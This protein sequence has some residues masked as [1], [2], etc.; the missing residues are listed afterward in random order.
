MTFESLSAPRSAAATSLSPPARTLQRKC[1]CGGTPGP[2]GECAECKRKRL[3]LQPKLAVNQPGD[4]YEQE[5]D[6]V[7]EAIVRGAGSTRPSISS[8]GKGGAVQRE[9]PAKPKAEEQK[10]KEA[11][12]KVGEAFLKTPPGKEIEK[13]AEELGDAFIS[14]L[15]GKIITGAAVTGAIATL[16]ATHKELPIGIPEIPLNRIKPGLKM[17]L[18]YEGPVDKPNK[19]MVGFSFQF[20]GG[21]ASDRKSGPS[22]SEKRQTETARRRTED[23][24]FREGLRSDEEKA[25]DARRLNDR[26][27]SRMLRPDQLTPR[28]SPLS[29]GVAG[30]ELGFHPGAPATGTRSALG[31]NT[32]TFRLGSET[33]TEAPKK[34]EEE[35]L[36]RKSADEQKVSAAPPVV[37]HVLQRPGEP[38]DSTTRA[39]MEERFGYDFGHVRIHSDAA[40]EKSARQ[41]N[42]QAYTV[43]YDIVFGA[44]RF[45]PRTIEGQRLIAHELTHVVQQSGSN[46]IEHGSRSEIPGPRVRVS[47]APS[48]ALRRYSL[49]DIGFS[50]PSAANVTDP[51]AAVRL[52]AQIFAVPYIGAQVQ[53]AVRASVSA[54]AMALIEM[55]PELFARVADVL[56]HPQEYLAQIKSTV[57]PHIE[58]IPALARME[59]EKR[60]A[61]LGMASAPLARVIRTVVLQLEGLGENWWPV[62]SGVITQQIKLWD[63]S[64]ET[65]SLEELDQKYSS[66]ALDTIDYG[67]QAV[68]VALGGLD[69]VLGA[70]GIGVWIVGL[71]GGTGAGTAGGGAVGTLA[72]GAGA[73]PGA[74]AGEGRAPPRAAP[75]EEVLEHLAH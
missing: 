19:V 7:A 36:Q 2:S 3:S 53:E 27:G 75:S 48:T 13:K 17:K 14:T 24:K 74:A 6:R 61:E 64:S 9:E 18:T 54:K 72:A 26:L 28:T 44:G 70:I 56:N 30:E 52:V 58:N 68:Q 67:L 22:E 73:A 33:Q 65:A 32:S 16:A 40:S 35:T 59:A 15:P 1:A 8:L 43:G 62:L 57:Q 12:K 46:G 23:A 50:L 60:L 51:A 69:R 39:F 66:G 37:N 31:P 25:A 11:A 71:V 5:A 38:L 20:G 55:N 47:R 4:R 10:Y 63:W 29:F 21:K 41:V 34:K 42:A 49:D 45:T